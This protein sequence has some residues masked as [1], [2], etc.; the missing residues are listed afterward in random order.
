MKT[1]APQLVRRARHNLYLDTQ[2]RYT[3]AR[4]AWLDANCIGCPCCH[5]DT[6]STVIYH[7]AN[8]RPRNKPWT[9]YPAAVV[10]TRVPHIVSRD[11]P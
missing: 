3:P 5:C 7:V 1:D 10:L 4:H 6:A 8:V 11:Y 2:A 9:T